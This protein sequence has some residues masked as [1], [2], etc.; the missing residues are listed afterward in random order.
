MDQCLKG[1][2]V[3]NTRPKGRGRQLNEQIR[4]AG[5]R[6]ISLPCLNI[7]AAKP[8]W[9]QQLPDLQRIDIAIFI[10]VNAVEYAFKG[11][12][13]KAID[14]PSS[15]QCLA[16]G[17]QTA[18]KLHQLGITE[19]HTSDKANSEALLQL[20]VLKQSKNK[21]ILL[22]KGQQGRELIA[23]SLKN[24][25]AHLRLLEVYQS[26]LP[27]YDNNQIKR[28]WQDER[29]DIILLTSEQIINNL[30]QMTDDDTREQCTDKPCIVLSP[31]LA[32]IAREAGFKNIMV[33]STDHIYDTLKEYYSK[34]RQ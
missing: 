31:R 5:G 34:G 25:G 22:F 30:L 16:I 29:V 9:L 19:V 26:N 14:W 7:Q 20:P 1:L 18:E 33:S 32:D 8:V 10:S 21:Y 2:T 6:V 27:V 3:L 12:K 15:I 23:Q 28:V 13:E 17:P 24:A 11:L 4:R